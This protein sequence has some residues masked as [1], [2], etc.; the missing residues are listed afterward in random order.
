MIA[1]LLRSLP[2]ELMLASG[3]STV[4]LFAAGIPFYRGLKIFMRA[5]AATRHVE[6]AEL[7]DE[8]TRA[9]G[10]IQ[11]ISHVMMTILRRSLRENVDQ[12]TDFVRDATRQYVLNDYDMT[13]AKPLSMYSNI[14][15]PIGFIGTTIGMMVLFM[16]LHLSHDTL[17]IG[18]LSVALSSTIFALLGFAALEGLR[19]RLYARLMRCVDDVLELQ[20]EPVV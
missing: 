16:S 3:V 9:R 11:P 17:Q 2:A 4:A 10:A 19:I 8:E 14:L 5:R 7:L 20:E 15:P 1:E 18:A 6:S 13:Y 12:P